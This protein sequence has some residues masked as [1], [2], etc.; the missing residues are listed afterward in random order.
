MLILAVVAMLFVWRERRRQFA[1]FLLWPAIGAIAYAA[2]A[3]HVSFLSTTPVAGIEFTLPQLERLVGLLLSP[4]RGL[5]IYS[6]VLVLAVPRLWRPDPEAPRWLAYAVIGVAGYLVLLSAYVPWWGGYC[7]GPRYLTD[8]LPILVLCAAAT[9]RRL[10]AS[11]PTRVLLVALTVWGVVVQAIG[12]YADDEA[13]NSE[14]TPVDIAPS[15]LWDWN[16]PQIVRAARSGW[17]GF[18]LAPLLWHSLL[19]PSAADLRP[20]AARDLAAELTTPERLPLRY[21]AR[22]TGTL[23]L[24]IANRSDIR[25]PAF[26]DYGY[27]QVEVL[28][29][30]W[31]DGAVVQGEGGFIALPWNL[32]ARESA[33]VSGRIETPR[34]PGAYELEVKMAQLLDGEKGVVG[35]ATLRMPVHIE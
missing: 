34:E 24:Q 16:D 19:H 5:F 14:P 2:Y 27:L 7:Y 26:T 22:R 28:Y 12:V 32:D 11:S 6:P 4:S 10:W 3:V 29:R 20:L 18:D 23:L 1:P 21:Q 13:W 30:W 33:T 31:R 8:L 15:R 17:H 35:D 25:W 9:M